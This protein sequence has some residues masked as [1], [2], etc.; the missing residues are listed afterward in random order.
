MAQGYCILT[1]RDIFKKNNGFNEKIHYG[2]DNDYVSRTGKYGFGFVDDTYYY[3][4]LRR[5]EQEGLAF[6]IKNIWHEI[7][8]LTHL[9]NLEN[10]PF[11]Y[12]FGKHKPREK[13]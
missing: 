8:R 1:R 2:E 9:D 10:Q 12:E 3:V 13:K 11:K 6:S 5:R 7:Y 4:D